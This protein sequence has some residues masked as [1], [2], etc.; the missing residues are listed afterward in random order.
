MRSVFFFLLSAIAVVAA[1]IR[2]VVWDEQQPR[3]KAAYKNFLGNAI[4]DHLKTKPGLKVRA[5]RQ[6]DPNKCIGADVLEHCDVL[7]WWGHVRQGQITPADCKP[8][9]DRI[10]AGKLAFLPLHSA[11]WATPFIEAMNERTKADVDKL[12][13]RGKN[14]PRVQFD[15]IAPAGRIPPARNS[16]VTPAY[17]A[18]QRRGVVTTVRVDLPNCCFP[19][20]R[21]DGKPSTMHILIEIYTKRADA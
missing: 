4:A 9:I 3:Q 19:A 16:L 10:K 5:V 8:I 2:V 21:G 15:Y 12:F 20:Y 6:D 7:I 18:L 13:P 1:D 17:L 14:S 11:H